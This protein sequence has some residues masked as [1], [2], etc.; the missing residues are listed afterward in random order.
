MS[1]TQSIRSALLFFFL[2]AFCGLILR[3]AFVFNLPEWIDFRN[4]RHA[5]SHVALLGW[6]HAFLVLYTSSLF[7]EKNRFYYRIFWAMQVA[8]LGMLISFPFL[9][10]A[11]LSIVFL[12][13]HI[14]LSF[15]YA[16]RLWRESSAEKH[17]RLPIL[18]MRSGLFFMMASTAGTLVLG[19]LIAQGLKGTAVYY[20]AIQFYLHFQFNGWFLFAA[21]AMSLVLFKN[22]NISYEEKE[23][24]RFFFLLLISTVLTY[25][26]AVTWSTPRL[27]IFTINSSGVLLQLAALVIGYLWLRKPFSTFLSQLQVLQSRLFVLAVVCL[28]GKVIVQSLVVLPYLAQVSYTVRNFVIGFIHL[29]MLGV[30]SSYGFFLASYIS[31]IKI[32]KQGVLLF[33]T[34]FL[35]SELMLF[36]Q[37]L[38][39]WQGWGMIPYYY[40]GLFAA[41]VIMW[42][43]IG[44]IYVSS[45]SKPNVLPTQV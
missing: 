11:S 31:S 5:H 23:G 2:A 12:A 39:L 10:Y 21:I 25:A 45:L 30:F 36:G 33:F 42:L 26:L 3:S 6:I 37:G 13:I 34:G 40:A 38:F 16:I 14:V 18:F 32:S 9:G 20:A 41:S 28:I 29:L 35:I 19:P 1:T 24:R 27:E 22:K 17:G 15:I 43:G 8:V 44:R 4:V 7:G